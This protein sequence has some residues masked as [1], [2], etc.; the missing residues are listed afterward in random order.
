[1]G[2]NLLIGITGGIATG[3]T[4]VA[5]MLSRLGSP[6]IDFDLLARVVQQPGKP[7][8]RDIVS[9]FGTNVLRPEGDLDRKKLSQIVFQDEH[10]RRRL[11]HFTHPRILKEYR[12]QITR[13]TSEKPAAIIQIVV[14][15]LIEADLQHM[16]DKLIL[17][18]VA[19]EE[20]L[21]RLMKRDGISKP[22]AQR[23]L[24]AQLSIEDKRRY[25]DYVIDNSLSLEHTQKQVERLWRQLTQLKTR[26]SG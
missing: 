17:V 11:E 18:Y 20:Q 25:A 22:R 10:K 24:A 21:R 2:T 15:L 26:Q 5:E 3:K 12:K 7:A 9:F 1:M 8:F 23:I 14:P 19:Q 16:F 13:L 6:L 4:T